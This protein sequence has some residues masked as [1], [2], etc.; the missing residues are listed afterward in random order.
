MVPR[1]VFCD[2]TSLARVKDLTVDRR[3]RPWAQRLRRR[4]REQ[5]LR[6][7]EYV[8]SRVKTIFA[9]APRVVTSGS[10]V[11]VL[12]RISIPCPVKARY[13]IARIL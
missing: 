4:R 3:V 10:R 8:S 2:P 5:K 7:K 9:K 12:A 6:R 11:S 13:F 1:F